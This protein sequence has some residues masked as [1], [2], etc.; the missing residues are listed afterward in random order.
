MRF[1]SSRCPRPRVMNSISL[2]SHE[3]TM[4]QFGVRP[5]APPGSRNRRRGPLT[6]IITRS[7]TSAMAA[8]LRSTMIVADAA[9]ADQFHDRP[10]F[11]RHQRRRALRSPRPL[12]RLRDWSSARGRPRASA[13]RRPKAA[14]AAADRAVVLGAETRLEVRQVEIPVTPARSRRL[15]R[16]GNSRFSRTALSVRKN[17][18]ALRDIGDTS[19]ARLMRLGTQSGHDFACR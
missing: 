7:D 9:L 15:R 2:I 13:A 3:M 1:I 12:A 4:L 10:D 5:T 6:R 11:P 17:A 18:T 8:R 19:R 16:A 14:A